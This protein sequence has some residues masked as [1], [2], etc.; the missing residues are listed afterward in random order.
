MRMSRQRDDYSSP[1]TESWIHSVSIGR[2]E[3]KG[4]GH[5]ITPA[6]SSRS[7]AFEFEKMESSHSGRRS[8][9]RHE[10]DKAVTVGSL[11][12]R[13][14]IDSKVNVFDRYGLPVGKVTPHSCKKMVDGLPRSLVFQRLDGSLQLTIPRE[15]IPNTPHSLFVRLKEY[16][17]IHQKALSRRAGKTRK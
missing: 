8:E 16:C 15:V 11:G 1:E 9:A 5:A 6:S 17:E 14:T 12:A 4:G 2:N 10:E 7:R 13:M 3:D